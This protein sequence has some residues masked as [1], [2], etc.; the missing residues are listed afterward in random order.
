MF[1]LILSSSQYLS[2]MSG[3]FNPFFKIAC[4]FIRW[5]DITLTYGLWV[6]WCSTLFSLVKSC[7][8]NCNLFVNDKISRPLIISWIYWHLLGMNS[9]QNYSTG[10]GRGCRIF[11]LREFDNFAD[12]DVFLLISQ[13]NTHCILK[14]YLFD[15]PEFWEWTESNVYA[16]IGS[17][18]SL[19]HSKI[20]TYAAIITYVVCGKCLLIN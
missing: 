15:T 14:F 11:K 9:W 18:V 20:Y 7:G 16:L 3:F 19:G 1:K 13:R 4:E 10:V 6:Q 12:V 2:F 17:F 5:C 8:D